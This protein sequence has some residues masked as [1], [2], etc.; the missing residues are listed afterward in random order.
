L[1][2]LKTNF[3]G[4]TTCHDETVA[5]TFRNSCVTDGT[6]WH[7]ILRG[8]V[9]H[10][11]NKIRASVRLPLVT[12]CR[13]GT[14]GSRS[15]G[16]GF[17]SRPFHYHVTSRTQT[18]AHLSPSTPLLSCPYY[19]RRVTHTRRAVKIAIFGQYLAF[20]RKRYKTD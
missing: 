19:S 3:Q 20:S 4:V 1:K 8:I 6:T 7:P 10:C 11:G 9:G 16:R 2:C 15:R 14:S 18:H 13:G 17:D 12:W 5:C